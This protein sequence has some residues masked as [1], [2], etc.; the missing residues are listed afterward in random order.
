[1]TAT[2]PHLGMNLKQLEEHPNGL[3]FKFKK[4]NGQFVH[5]YYKGKM[6]EKSGLTPSMV[7]NR[8]LYEIMPY[9][10]AE[11]KNRLYEKA[12][13][14]EIIYYEGCLNNVHYF[15]IL[16]P[17][18]EMGKTAE[19]LGV[20][21]DVT[22]SRLLEKKIESAERLSMVGQLAAGV[23]HEICN[24]LTSLKGF[25][26]ILREM[27]TEYDKQHYLAI[28]QDEVERIQRIV[29][30]FILL[31]KPHEKLNLRKVNM[32][33]IVR[34]AVDMLMPE[35][36]LHRLNIK[37]EAHHDVVAEGDTALIR[38]MVLN[39]LQ[40]AIDASKE[41][42]SEIFVS[43]KYMNAY[44]YEIKIKDF[45]HGISKERQEKLFQPF[46]TTKE[47]GVGL[48]LMVCKRIVELHQG[49]IHLTS[50][51]NV[52]TEVIVELPRKPQPVL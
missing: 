4:I 52:G 10:E 17:V 48:G 24:P 42:K 36:A 43:V 13:N 26:Q 45:G 41:R 35:I 5:T 8:T 18:K 11:E 38:Q 46:Y 1:M 50:K 23:A 37:T 39:L 9:E 44:F 2:I 3:I 28:M 7:L 14:G 12:W 25:T 31:S 32:T 51:E 16:L 22:R 6:I 30:E 15:A 49:N 33:G 29:K 34:E 40:N 19:V 21:F 20:A 47:K 27:I